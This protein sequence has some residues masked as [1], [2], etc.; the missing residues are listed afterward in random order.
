MILKGAKQNIILI[1]FSTLLAAFSLTA[2]LFFTDPQTAGTV[3][4]LFL[5]LSLFLTA[6]GVCILVGI[7]IRQLFFPGLYIGQMSESF[8]QG[9][10]IAL[11]VTLSLFLQSQR[12]L[13]WWVEASLILLFT[14]IEIFSNLKT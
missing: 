4:F 11:L 10:L 3:T 12:L 1:G 7:L 9:I 2:I 13:Y 8:R 5:Y 6:L 14:S